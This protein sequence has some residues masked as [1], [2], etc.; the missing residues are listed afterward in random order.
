[1]GLIDR[2]HHAAIM[3]GFHHAEMHTNGAFREIVAIGTAAVFVV[4]KIAGV[5]CVAFATLV[6]GRGLIH[7]AFAVPIA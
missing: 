7:F 1:M 5:V 2:G 3:K 4:P 6:E